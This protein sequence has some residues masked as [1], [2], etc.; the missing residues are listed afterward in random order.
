M[1]TKKYLLPVLG[2]FISMFIL[3]SI[4]NL[5]IVRNFVEGNVSIARAEPMIA[6]V[7]AG[8][9]LLAI[10]MMYLYPKM[11]QTRESILIN[12]F[13]FGALIGLL[14][15]LPFNIVLH[16]VYDFPQIALVID[17][18]WSIIEQ[19]MGGIVLALLYER[20]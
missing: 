1:D 9:L 6:F 18:A 2:T 4:W 8:Y 11:I 19:G 13:K 12:G 15:M 5:F 7:A 16:G 14:W 17:T 10:F 3:S 20:L